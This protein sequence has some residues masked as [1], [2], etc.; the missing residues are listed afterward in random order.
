M[1]KFA[2]SLIIALAFATG[3]RAAD[4][5]AKPALN[6]ATV[7]AVSKLLDS[8]NYRSMAR[9]IMQVTSQQMQPG[10]LQAME[11][12]I[13]SNSELDAGQKAEALELAKSKLPAL[14]S[15]LQE[16]F[17]DPALIEEMQAATVQ[18]YARNFSVGEI[19]QLAA[20]YRT[21]L[22]KKM[23]AKMPAIASESVV[24]SQQVIMPR[25]EKLMREIVG[26]FE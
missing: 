23:L 17:A 19:E 5:Q 22:G 13:N 8:M 20:F 2:V 3:A 6:P 11:A 15:K 16:F 18:V 7:A 9:Q 12:A 21:P 25:L 24:A 14:N 1:K 4:E 10:M 26:V